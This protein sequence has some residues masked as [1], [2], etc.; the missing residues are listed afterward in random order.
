ML[1]LALPLLSNWSWCGFQAV[2]GMWS[3]IF[4]FLLAFF[5]PE[6]A[7]PG[8]RGI[9]KMQ[10]SNSANVMAVTLAN[11]FA[12]LTDYALVIAYTIAAKYG[13]ESEGMIG[14][15]FVPTGLG[16]FDTHSWPCQ[17]SYPILNRTTT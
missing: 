10:S 14:A 5:F 17:T 7:L 1:I 4:I 3:V 9:D 11:T 2:L 6:M 12:I 15:F 13:F 16:N 8:S